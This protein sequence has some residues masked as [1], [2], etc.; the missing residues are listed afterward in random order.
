M[1]FT[2]KPASFDV[3]KGTIRLPYTK[4]LPKDMIAVWCYGQY[5]K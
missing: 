4:P 1:V 5:A 3:S 2:E